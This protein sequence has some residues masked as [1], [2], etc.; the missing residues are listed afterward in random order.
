MEAEFWAHH[1]AENAGKG[2][3]FEDEDFDL[4]EAL[5]QAG[6]GFEDEADV[7]DWEEI[8]NDRA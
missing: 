5:A 3:E 2:E 7:D 6:E 8:V 4:A 1:Y